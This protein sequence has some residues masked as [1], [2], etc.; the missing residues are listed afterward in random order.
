MW[1]RRTGS[2]ARHALL[3]GMSIGNRRAAYGTPFG[4][5]MALV[6][7]GAVVAC[8]LWAGRLLALPAEERVFHE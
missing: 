8:W 1:S 5:I 6:G 3:L 2:A 7:I 4:Q